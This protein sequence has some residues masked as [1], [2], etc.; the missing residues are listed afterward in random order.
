[1][2]QRIKTYLQ[3]F[4]ILVSITTFAQ[5][6]S[7]KVKPTPTPAPVEDDAE[8]IYTEEIKLNVLAFDDDGKFNPVLNKEDLVINE[9]NVLHQAA[10]VRR[11]PA[12]VLIV[13]DTGGDLRQM[14]SLQQTRETAKAIVSGLKD[15]DS[16]AV[17]QYADQPQIV[18]E[19]TTDKAQ[20]L[21]AIA[22]KTNFGR[23]DAFVSAITMATD[24][25][26]KNPLDN[27][28]LILITDGTDTS[29]SA[30]EKTAV[31]RKL[32]A[33]DINVHIISYTKMEATDIEP[34]TKIISNTPPPR[35]MPPEVAAQLPPGVR[36]MA[37]APKIGPTINIDRAMLK[38][39]RDR[40]KDLIESEKAL[41]T[42]AANTNGEFILPETK[43]EMI[44]KSA[45]VAQMIDASY[46][47]TYV[48][49][50]PLSEARRNE[51]RSIEITSR[52]AGL[53]VEAKR[54][55]LVKIGN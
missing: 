29:A 55:L 46:V 45:L 41:S 49:K 53:Q 8:K 10:S 18:A 47:V 43:A 48:P 12:N 13:M 3:L 22:K 5:A 27:K 52:R 7:G 6:Q 32:L 26:E 34:R 30:A 35:A 21:N 16:I 19:W 51:E 15:G 37:T 36:D 11:I 28:H 1:M 25:L 31:M 44:D 20:I 38:R 42:L 17:M 50:K 2:P 54:K 4:L 39:A 9:D 40:K 24:F 33:T 14:K 23:H